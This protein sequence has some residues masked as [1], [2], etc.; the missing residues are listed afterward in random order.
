MPLTPSASHN[1]TNSVSSAYETWALG[2]FYQPTNSSFIDKGSVANA[3]LL[4]F[5]HYTVL[6][7]QTKEATNKL[8][9]GFHYIALNSNNMPVDSDS[10]GW[11][12]YWEDANGNGSL[13]HRETKPND[14]ADPGLRVFITRPKSGS[15]IP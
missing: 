4:G 5:Y 1:V 9:L 15:T 11:P 6:T 3:S 2:F 7:N 10:D 14:A 13:D 8:D 12:D